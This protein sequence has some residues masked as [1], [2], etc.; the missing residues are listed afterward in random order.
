MSTTSEIGA[1]FGATLREFIRLRVRD[2]HVVDDVLQDVFVRVHCSS[3]GCRSHC[4]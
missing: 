4:C 1:G 2:D 3:T